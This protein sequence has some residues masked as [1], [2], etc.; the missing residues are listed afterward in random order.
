MYN[1]RYLPKSRRHLRGLLDSTDGILSWSLSENGR[2]NY[3]MNLSRVPC[4]RGPLHQKLSQQT[5]WPDQQ[6]RAK[7]LQLFVQRE[8]RDPKLRF[9]WFNLFNCPKLV[10]LLFSD[11]IGFLLPDGS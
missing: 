2:H 11:G 5:L 4:R 10:C 8:L 9:Y 1:S 6:P 3:S 7:R